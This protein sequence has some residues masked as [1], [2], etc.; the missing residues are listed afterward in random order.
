MHVI[1]LGAGISGC[2]IAQRLANDGKF[3]VS[4][5]D[6]AHEPASETSAH[7]MALVHPQVNK[8]STKLQRF[9]QLANRI[10]WQKYASSIRFTGAFQPLENNPLIN[11]QQVRE[12]LLT[13]NYNDLEVEYLNR[14]QALEQLNVS[15]HGIWF[16]TAGIYNLKKISEDALTNSKGIKKF[17]QQKIVKLEKINNTWQVINEQKEVIC[18]GDAIVL[19]TNYQTK[20]LLRSLEPELLIRPVK[21]QLSRFLIEKESLVGKCLPKS[22]VR[23]D[24]YCSPR[25]AWN[26]KYW[27]WEVGSSYEEDVDELIPTKMAVQENYQKGLALLNIENMSD[28]YLEHSHFMGIRCASKDR[29][30][31]IGPIPK[32]S[33]LYLATAY[34]SRGLIWATLGAEL[35]RRYL[36]RF[37]STEDF[38]AAGFLTDALGSGDVSSVEAEIAESV[39]PARFL[40]GTFAA[41]RASNSKPTFPSAPKAK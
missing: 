16:K 25:Q 31:L 29:L 18:R 22:V 21:G 14:D 28:N 35:I 2:L 36:E 1:V 30:P 19:A 32:H 20:N 6:Q 12:L 23:G 10:I 5:I 39:A 33:G 24:G 11:E 9:T 26:D 17:W 15:S 40:A 8:K 13:L 37:L 34:G 4:L 27:M 38:L 3:Q 7:Q 41:G